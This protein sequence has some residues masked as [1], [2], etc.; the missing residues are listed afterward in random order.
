MKV[1]SQTGYTLVEM[2]VVLSIF[3]MLV[4]VTLSYIPKY[5]E[6]KEMHFFLRQFSSDY[7]HAQAYAI[8]HGVTV[9]FTIDPAKRLYFAQLDTEERLYTKPIP[10]SVEH[11]ETTLGKRIYF[12]SVG[13]VSKSGVWLFAGK[14]SKYSFTVM[15]GRGRHYYVEY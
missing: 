14:Y 8:S 1:N 10:K 11:R 4:S 9:Y 12:N 7:F 2:L 15:L 3:L 13:N 6:K 5:K